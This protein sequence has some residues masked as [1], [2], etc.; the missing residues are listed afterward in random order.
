[1][2][3]LLIVFLFII[4]SNVVNCQTAST[5]AS[6]R[7]N[8]VQ[9]LS[10][11]S[12]GGALNFGDIILTGS[13]A[14]FQIT[15]ALGQQFRITGNP[16]RSVSI[17]FNQISLSNSVWVSL[18]GG[19]TGTLVFIPAVVNSVNNPITSGNF[20]PLVTSGAV[21]ILDIRVGGSITVS[22]TQPQGDYTGTFTI[23]VSY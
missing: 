2:K 9:P 16:G 20:Y 1:M 7:V 3:Q 4:Y 6:G 15:P 19:T 8:A 18:N 17:T 5:T 23:S 10:I 11:T 14:S 12:T 21:A 22:S 13:I